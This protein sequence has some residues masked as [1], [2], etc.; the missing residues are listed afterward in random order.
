[1]RIALVTNNFF[2]IIS[3]VSVA[4][5]NLY[6]ELT[7]LGHKIFI[8]APHHPDCIEDNKSIIRTRSI[9]IFYRAK[10]PLPLSTSIDLLELFKK[11][12][13]DIVHSHHPFGLG[14]SALKACKEYSNIPIVFTNH[15]LYTEYTHYIPFVARKI[16]IHYINKTVNRYI[17]GCD[18]TIVPNERL[19][20]KLLYVHPGKNFH[21]VPT[22]ISS[23]LIKDAECSNNMTSSL[24]DKQS[25]NFNILCVSR[26]AREKNINFIE[27]ISDI[28]FRENSKYRIILVGGGHLIRK[29][30]K[31]N[32]NNL[33]VFGEIE[34]KKISELY[35]RSKI[36]LFVS[37]TD[38]QGLPLVES[39]PFGLP[40]VALQ[41]EASE[42]FVKKIKTG[43]IAS[44]NPE[45]FVETM[46]CLLESQSM[47][48][49]IRYN[50]K[51]ICDNFSPKYLAHKVEKIY[52]SLN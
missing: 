1:M 19:K 28:L 13:I 7:K 51:K 42:E 48:N 41:S 33:I 31:R 16:S 43:I 14:Q 3:G 18:A 4:V 30:K 23:Y 52:Q 39:L 25:D 5:S 34:H 46:L 6:D 21:T 22:W 15:T 44:D 20:K 45:S 11:L 2:P 29:L 9:P 35:K 27:K 12:R 49:T 26:L 24:T 10:Y 37:K 38:T 40:I 47:L 8:V 32:N 36:L 50:N 17:N